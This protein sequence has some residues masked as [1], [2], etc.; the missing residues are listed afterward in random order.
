MPCSQLYLA[1]YFEDLFDLENGTD[2][3][4]QQ[5]VYSFLLQFLRECEGE[6]PLLHVSREGIGM[7][8]LV[9]SGASPRP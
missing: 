6:H 9:M 7:Q 1:E 2:R 3:P 4:R 5:E 8:E